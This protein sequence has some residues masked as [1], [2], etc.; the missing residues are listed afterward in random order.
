MLNDLK[1]TFVTC[2]RS[3]M[4]APGVGNSGQPRPSLL[5][6]TSEKK[7]YSYIFF[8]EQVFI[9]KE[10][11]DKVYWDPSK[12][13]L[14]SFEN[15]SVMSIEVSSTVLSSFLRGDTEKQMTW[16]YFMSTEQYIS[17]LTFSLLGLN[18]ASRSQL[19]HPCYKKHTFVICANVYHILD[20]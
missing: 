14:G 5:A 6:Q 2:Q 11:M 20:D 10:K 1:P 4:P 8:H 19:S 7:F 16:S 9:Q 12:S 18:M 17:S 13:I 15:M 3:V